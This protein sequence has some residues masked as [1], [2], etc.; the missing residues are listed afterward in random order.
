MEEPVYFTEDHPA[1][2]QDLQWQEAIQLAQQAAE[3]CPE[4]IQQ[5][6]GR[7]TVQQHLRRALIL[8]GKVHKNGCPF[9]KVSLDDF[10]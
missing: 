5:S 9:G 10:C 1:Q 3:R 6:P 2:I 7:C 8:A 4:T